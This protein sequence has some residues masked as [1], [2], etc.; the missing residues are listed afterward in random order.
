MTITNGV[1]GHRKPN[2]MDT[3]DDALERARRVKPRWISVRAIGEFLITAGLI[4]LLFSGYE[5]WGKAAIVSA[6]QNELDAALNRLWDEQPPVG[7]PD[8]PGPSPSPTNG[9]AS[10]PPPG[11]AIARL[12]IPTLGKHWVV[13]EGVEPKDIAYAPGHYPRSAMPGQV[14]NFS[15][16]GHRSPAIFWDLDLLK[17]GKGDSGDVIVVETRSRYY[18]YRVT[19]K[20]IVLPSQSE[21]VAPNPYDPG[22]APSQRLLTLTTCNPKWD[23]THRL[24]IHASLRYSQDRSKGPPPELAG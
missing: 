18:V 17:A 16:A 11:W 6:K 22:A 10:K 7:T 13:V 9:T 21:V 1:P 12:Y 14:G 8:N 20:L 15:V 5:I 4:L 23:N 2:L 24:I 3:V 19:Q